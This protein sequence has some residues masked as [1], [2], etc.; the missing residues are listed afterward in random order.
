MYLKIFHVLVS[1]N[2][3]GLFAVLA[4]LRQMQER[5]TLIEAKLAR[6]RQPTHRPSSEHL[7]PAAAAQTSTDCKTDQ[8]SVSQKCDN[9]GEKSLQTSSTVA[10][11]SLSAPQSL[12]SSGKPGVVIFVSCSAF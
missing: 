7:L 6:S 2:V 5:I 12:V 1:I 4:E 8:V 9:A 3:S 11:C 10:T